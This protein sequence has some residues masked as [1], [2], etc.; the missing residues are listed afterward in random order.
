MDL[1]DESDLTIFSENIDKKQIEVKKKVWEKLEPTGDT[2][3][4]IVEVVLEYIKKHR[5]KIYGSYAH[6]M[7]V[8]HKNKKDAFLSDLEVPDIDFYSPEPLNDLYEICNIFYDLGYKNVTGQEAQH[9][10]TYKIFV[11]DAEACDISYVPTMIY[12]KIQFIEIDGIIYTH[13]MWSVIDYFRILSDPLTSWEFKLDKRFTRLYLLLKNY[14]FPI[15]NSIQDQKEIDYTISDSILEFVK[16]RSSIIMLGTYVYNEYTKKVGNE[17]QLK[18]P[19]YEMI[20]A[21]YCSDVNMLI[22]TLQKKYGSDITADEYYPYFQF[23]DFSVRIYN[24]TDLICIIY[25]NNRKCVPKHTID[26]VNICSMSVFILYSLVLFTYH[27]TYD[28]EKQKQYYMGMLSKSIKMRRE[29]IKTNKTDIMNADIFS[30]FIVDC[31]GY[32]VTAKKEQSDRI[33]ENMA[34][35]KQAMFR[36]KPGG[37]KRNDAHKFQFKNSSGN[38]ITNERNNKLICNKPQTTVP[39]TPETSV[40]VERDNASNNTS[41]YSDTDSDIDSYID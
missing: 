39:D 10:E 11:D 22:E 4:K 17:K 30:D 27:R 33:R 6:N 19:Y 31:V 40:S 16:N 15:V 23:L 26:N 37:D 12:N 21:N 8:K 1:Y 13:P 29:Y 25:S 7:T 2:K 28:N 18:I 24:K 5:R 14:P 41:D 3:M 34:Q 35:G 32:T 20:S 38:K 36:Y 9:A